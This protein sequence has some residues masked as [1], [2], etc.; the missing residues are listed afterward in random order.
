MPTGSHVEPL[1]RV[2]RAV[3]DRN[4]VIEPENDLDVVVDERMDEVIS[5]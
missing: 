4:L 1:D 2:P 5:W 3:F